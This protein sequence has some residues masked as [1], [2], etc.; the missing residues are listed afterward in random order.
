M[1]ESWDEVGQAVPAIE[2]VF[3]F[4]EV[5]LCVLWPEGVIAAAQ[6]RL[7]VVEHGIDP[8]ELR[9]LQGGAPAPADYRPVPASGPGHAVEAFQTVGNH[10][11][12]GARCR[13]AQSAM[14][15][16]RKPL[17]PL[18]L[19]RGGAALFGGLHC[20]HERGL[21]LGAS[22]PL[23]A[24]PL[25]AQIGIVPRHPAIEALAPDPPGHHRHPLVLDAPGGIVGTSR[26]A[27]QLH[28]RDPLLG[29][30]QQGD[31]LEPEGQR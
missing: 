3:E 24:A 10:L 13:P 15:D 23:A 9:F 20:G 8:V 17:T 28:R 1:G 16:F 19:M 27:M 6:G 22:S 30:G 14:C 18:S 12:A 29:L 21:A 2:A 31:R 26:L 4:G 25:A 7:Q 11:A 5:A